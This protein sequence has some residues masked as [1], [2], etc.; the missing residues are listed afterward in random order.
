MRPLSNFA[1]RLPMAAHP[2]EAPAGVEGAALEGLTRFGSNPGALRA[3]LHVPASLKPGAA[4]VVVLH[5]CTQTAAG[6]D[7]G[8]GWS[9]LADQHGFAVLLPEQQRANNPNGCFNWFVPEDTRRGAG[10]A[11]SIREMTAAAVD[12]HALDPARVFIT[13]LS[14]GGAMASVMLATYPE[15]FAGGGIIAGLPF[16][17][18]T[19]VPE[20]LDRMRGNGGPHGAELA[21]LVRAASRH[22]GPWPTVSVWQGSADRTVAPVNAR[23]IVDQWRGVHEVEEPHVSDVV[24]NYPHLAWRN[25]SGKVVVEQFEIT[26]MGHGTP[27]QTSGEGDAIGAAGPFMLEAGI[28]STHHLARAWCLIGSAPLATPQRTVPADRSP[29]RDRSWLDGPARVIDDA[30]RAAGLVR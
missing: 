20:A 19:G 28:S 26:G 7:H 6:Y 14:A 25:A 30:L 5:G 8:S 10:E 24:M 27:L 21:A 12:A 15:V 29:I 11:L 9:A 22:D 4:L 16:G 23:L 3:W 1:A 2:A 18:A 17:T 13:G